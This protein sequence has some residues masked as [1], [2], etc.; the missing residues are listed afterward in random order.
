M[1]YHNPCH[2]HET[3]STQVVA[4]PLAHLTLFPSLFSLIRLDCCDNDVADDDGC[5]CCCAYD[6]DDADDDGGVVV[7]DWIAV[8]ER[9]VSEVVS[10]SE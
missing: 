10:E 1:Q 8:R 2:S 4:N 9:V 7:G 5:C 6:G 3:R